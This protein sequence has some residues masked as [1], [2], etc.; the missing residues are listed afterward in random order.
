MKRLAGDI[1]LLPQLLNVEKMFRRVSFF[2]G[3]Q[4]IFRTYLWESPKF[5]LTSGEFKT[6]EKRNSLNSAARKQ[7][8][9]PNRCV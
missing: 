5:D 7:L 3:D 8:I 4:S 6:T 2:A 1:C 9:A